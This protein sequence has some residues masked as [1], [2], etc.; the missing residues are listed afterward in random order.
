V[1]WQCCGWAHLQRTNCPRMQQVRRAF[2]E[3]HVTVGVYMCCVARRPSAK[4]LTVKQSPVCDFA[5]ARGCL[6]QRVAG[7]GCQQVAGS[8][9]SCTGRRTTC[10]H[11]RHQ[12]NMFV[13]RH[14][15]P[16]GI[17]TS[18]AQRNMKLQST[19][20]FT[21]SSVRSKFTVSSQPLC[22]YCFT[23]ISSL[24]FLSQ[25]IDVAIAVQCSER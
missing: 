16:R 1:I 8:N 24:S 2:K 3:G 20:Q 17:S 14:S 10:Q 5:A 9:P 11:Q 19:S 13:A 7:I 25:G 22:S 15:P 12:V 4:G 23:A 21:V 18:G 6:L